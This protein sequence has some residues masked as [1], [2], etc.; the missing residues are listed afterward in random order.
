MSAQDSGAYIGSDVLDHL[1]SCEF[2]FQFMHL[3][4]SLCQTHQP[5]LLTSPTEE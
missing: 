2:C 5:S 3:G 4:L 1:S